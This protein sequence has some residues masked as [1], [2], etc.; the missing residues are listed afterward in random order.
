MSG[1]DLHDVGAMLGERPRTRRTSEDA[2]QI[3]HAD[4]REWPVASWQRLWVTV[5][6]AHDFQQRQRSDRNG[7]RVFRPLRLRAS[8]AAGTIRGN[9]GLLEVGGVPGGNGTRHGVA[10]LRHTKHGKRRRA[11]VGEIAV[12]ITPASV[13]RGIDTHD[14]VLRGWNAGAGKF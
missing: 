14:A 13:P 9:D 11:M 1:G 5:A 4:I 8:H 3:E 2:R 6:N 12:Q 7:L 10:I